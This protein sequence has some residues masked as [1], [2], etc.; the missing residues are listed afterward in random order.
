[1]RLLFRLTKFLYHKNMKQ[2]T[3]GNDFSLVT[4]LRFFH[5]W[6]K[7]LLL[8]T[9]I[10]FVLSLVTSLLITPR[11][12]SSVVFFPTSSNRMS[13]AIITDR[14]DFMDYGSERDC[15]YAIQILS[16]Q[17][18]MNDV[19][20]HFNLMEHYDIN[21]NATDKNFQLEEKYKGYVTV[22][23]TEYLGVE[24][25][26]MDEDPQYA[27]DIANFM[28]EN[29]DSLCTRIHKAR[30]TDACLVLEGVCNKLEN[31]ILQLEDS[32]GG[33]YNYSDYTNRMY[34]ELA[35]QTSAGNSAAANR[36]R[37]EIA[38][39]KSIKGSYAGINDM[40]Q[41]KRE[42]LAEIQAKLAQRQTD[43]ENNIS[44]KYWLD[45]AVPADK[46]AYPKRL[47][48][49]ALSTISSLIMCILVL[50]VME[51]SKQWNI[52]ADNKQE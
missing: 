7:V 3:F 39:H 42:E 23:R 8:V 16:S 40:L 10:A 20:T 36:I 24:V 46:K 9:I 2:N 34:Q 38:S 14:Y 31:E 52:T 35:K 1:M 25:S 41:T 4:S 11:Y 15:E 44:Y 19:C 49:V 51:R 27:A 43:L 6:R 30:A 28:A 45:K 33:L 48:I 50:L 18:M 13:K 22:Q 37:S 47:I 29:Y 5:K 17:A 12:K 21:A 26:V 32:L